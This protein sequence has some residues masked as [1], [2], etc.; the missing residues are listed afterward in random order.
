MSVRNLDYLLK[1]RSIAVIGA[2]RRAKSVGA[3]LSRNLFNAG[4]EGPVMPVNPREQSVESTL[5]YNTIQD[6]PLTPDLAVLVIP[7]D[8]VPAA[9]AELGD[10]GTKAA[11][12]VTAGFGEGGDAEGKARMQALLDAAR[13][14]LMRIIGPNCLGIM[15]PRHGVNASFVHINPL[16]G[17]IAF[18]TQS[19][20]VATAV[21]DW[22]TYRGIGFSH[23]VSLGNM[24]D[25]DFGDMLDYLAADPDTKSILLYIES[26]TQARK[27]MSAGR[28]AARIKPVIVL[29]SGRTDAAAKA[30]ASHTGALAG[31]DAV[32]DAA[33][34]RAGMLRVNDMV[35]LFDAVETLATGVRIKGERL[36]ILTNGG[37]MG[38]LA[39]ESLIDSGGTLSELAPETV[40]ALDEVLP[41]TWSKAN[42]V[43]IIGDAPGERYAK[44]MNVLLKDPN[45]DAVLVLN[46]P[47]AI[48]DSREAAEA[49]VDA[50]AKQPDA[51]VL[52]SWL[53]QGAAAEARQLFARN[54]L[55]TYETPGQATSAFMHLVNHKRNQEL[56]VQTPPSVAEL[57]KAEPERAREI[58][59]A[60]LAD[61]RTMLNEP[62]SKAVLEAYQIPVVDTRIART[63]EEAAQ[64]AEK[65]GLPVALKILSPDIVHKTDKGGVRLN[66]HSADEV[67]FAAARMLANLQ[68]LEPDARIDGFTVQQMANMPGASELIVGI[69]EDP[70]FGA[71][72]LFGQGGTK[73]EVVKDKVISLPPLNMVLAREMM[74]HTRIYQELKGYRNIKPVDLDAVALTMIK[75]SQMVTDLTE[76]TELDINPLLANDKG[77][78][79]LDARIGIRPPL[80]KGAPRRTAIRPVPHWLEKDI[81]LDNGLAFRLRP[82]RPE[83][84]PMV[85]DMVHRC[86][87]E[88]TR[89]RFFAPLRELPHSA[90]IRFTQ[91]DY[92]REMALVAVAPDEGDGKPA[93]HGVVRITADPDQ[94]N[95]EF[96]VMVRSDKKGVG[97]GYRMMQ[98]I[99]DYARERGLKVIFG[100]ILRENHTMIEMC[101]S[102]GFAHSA[103]PDEPQTMVR[104]RI[105]LEALP[106]A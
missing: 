37:G 106:A 30:A 21:V 63:P 23:V 104:A 10:R 81:T 60:A 19:G 9:I 39:T 97:L 90:A 35:E 103:H 85:Q 40:A 45:T 80:A 73:V 88:D 7:P 83:D 105:D 91:I 50:L 12:V 24:A 53:G 71:V 93:I 34:R 89:L 101:R 31:A 59:H 4:F 41:A 46:C 25:V 82:I 64:L 96:A 99:I 29:K 14:H 15:L 69:A 17:D 20:A 1:P 49:V 54:R 79:A 47:Q 6:L 84:L 51:P 44:A 43:D 62:E 5:C 61:Q 77:V 65:I 70:I 87:P 8:T 100:E 72:L 16:P 66:L 33:F 58:I 86:T 55:P 74:T 57:F 18:V 27:F 3:V 26:V 92:D 22:A 42:P 11:V 56:L 52:T 75:L 48:A 32:Y 95:A 76:V 68:G 67:H 13:P 102:L 38:V 36:T 98:E 78:L 2:S 94:E 28:A